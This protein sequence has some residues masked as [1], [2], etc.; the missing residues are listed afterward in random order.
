MARNENWIRSAVLLALVGAAVGVGLMETG[1]HSASKPPVK[2]E[3]HEERTAPSPTAASPSIKAVN[4][5][6][7]FGKVKA[8]TKV[9]H[10]F[11]VRNEG[12]GDLVIQKAKG[13]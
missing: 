5:N 1:E 6:H 10:T 2:K 8:G 12:Q 3:Q 7:S 13:S 11:K 4:P 9:T